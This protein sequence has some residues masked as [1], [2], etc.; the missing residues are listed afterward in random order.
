MK[1]I[2][3]PLS[4][5]LLCTAH[6]TT[7]CTT[8]I[9]SGKSTRDGRP[10]IW[11]NRDTG[12]LD[13]KLSYCT[14]GKYNF[15]GVFD[16]VDSAETDCFM[17]SNDAGLCI[18]NTQSYNLH[19]AK[20]SGK[21]DKEGVFMREAL[22]TCATLKE[23][24]ALLEVT[25]GARGVEANFGVIDAKG[26]AAYY[27]TD[28]YSY[29]KF[30]VNDP[31][32][33]PHGYLVRTNFSFSG[34]PDDGQGYIRYQTAS[35]LFYWGYLSHALSVEFIL[36]DVARS[37]THSL[38][39]TNLL[40]TA[41]PDNDAE[42]TMISF[43]DFIPRFSTASSLI[44]EGVKPGE[45]PRNTT[46]WLVLGNPLMTPVVPV[47]TAMNTEQPDPLRSIGRKP[48]SLNAAAR[49]VHARCFPVRTP[50]GERYMDLAAVLNKRG[51][52]SLQRVR[53]FDAV[54]LAAASPLIDELRSTGFDRKKIAA[55]YRTLI[56]RLTSFSSLRGSSGAND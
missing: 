27:E 54:T 39:G 52:G 36:S 56:G 22:A 35:D 1:K 14:G 41:P 53:E 33:A 49:R 9:I 15:T 24:E 25:S 23:F 21:M 17:G 47:W 45:D 28:P 13:N 50:E 12:K 5:L 20:F 10:I 31:L 7:A 48:A 2:F 6:V 18:I 16:L 37:M 46:L 38:T 30:D 11:K 19:Y 32:T 42:R 26:G 43:V 55:F 4:I 34:T 29:K 8:V 40:K 3:F 51:T 44:M